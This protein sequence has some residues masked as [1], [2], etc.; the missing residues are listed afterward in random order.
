[1]LCSV[2]PSC[3]KAHREESRKISLCL[4]FGRN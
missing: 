2:M 1:V 3:Q 4:Q